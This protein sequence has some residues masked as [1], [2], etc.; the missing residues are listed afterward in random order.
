MEETI[1]SEQHINKISKDQDTARNGD[2]KNISIESSSL[3]ENMKDNISENSRKEN[4]VDETNEKENTICENSINVKSQ[5]DNIHKNKEIAEEKQESEKR[6]NI[7]Q[8]KDQNEENSINVNSDQIIHNPITDSS[9]DCGSNIDLKVNDVKQENTNRVI[10]E[11]LEKEADKSSNRNYINGNSDHYS[12]DYSKSNKD[13]SSKGSLSGNKDDQTSESESDESSGEEKEDSRGNSIEFE[14]SNNPQVSAVDYRNLIGIEPKKNKKAINPSNFYEK[15]ITERKEKE[16]KLE[17]LRKKLDSE[18]KKTMTKP[19]INPGSKKIMDKKQGI[20][21]PIYER[22]KEIEDTKKTKI[23]TIKKTVIDKKVKE[24]EEVMKSKILNTSKPYDEKEFSKWMNQ[25]TEWQTNKVKKIE[26]EKERK[27]KQEEEQISKY[28]QPNILKT[29]MTKSKME[30]S[31]YEKLYSL[32]DD[33]KEKLMQKILESIPDFKPQINKKVPKFIQN[34]KE[35]PLTKLNNFNTNKEISGSKTPRKS[36]EIPYNNMYGIEKTVCNSDRT[37]RCHAL[38]MH[39][40]TENNT[41]YSENEASDDEVPQRIGVQDEII[42]QYKKA[43]EMTQKINMKG[44]LRISE[45][46]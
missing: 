39:Y 34:K 29:E 11:S 30:T 12:K 37:K 25:T 10:N 35:L 28:Y 38:S 1:R 2:N 20:V 9:R 40:N 21:K 7:V 6:I 36:S 22:A 41:I 44:N 27:L 14:Q 17:V 5:I 18:V 33:K 4:F 3:N 26:S 15:K 23:E 13:V 31:I 19:L 32:K 46:K 42:N 43:L 8:Q 16:K 45:K 24:E